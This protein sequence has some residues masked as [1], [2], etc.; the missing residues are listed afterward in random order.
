MGQGYIQCPLGAWGKGV[1][2]EGGEWGGP[3]LLCLLCVCAA[4]GRS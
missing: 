4:T 2:E 3:V 1:T